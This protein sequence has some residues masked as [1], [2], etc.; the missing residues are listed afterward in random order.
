M[1]ARKPT[2]GA[3]ELLKALR[4]RLG[5]TTRDVERKSQQIAE[6]KRN[7]EY[8]LS[9]AW[10]T[11][12]ENG[13]FT[14]SIYKLYSLSAIYDQSF[15]ELLSFFGLRIGDLY[16]DRA[17]I[18][19][20]K[21]H[22]LNTASDM[23]VQKVFLPVQFKPEFRLERTNLLARVVEKWDEVPV[24][25]LQHLDLRKSMYGYIGLQDFT[26]FPLIRPGS[27]VQIDPSERKISSAKWKTEFDRPIYFIE[28]RDGYACSWCQ[29]D[30]GQLMV[31]PHPHSHQDVRRFEYPSEAEIVGRVTGLAMR[32]VG[33]AILGWRDTSHDK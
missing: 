26:L 9:H 1:D 3:G 22:L 4:V 20:P 14:P 11:D 24:G 15:T 17:S 27:L 32:I 16:R 23:E 12:I 19:V 31:I 18:G 7:Q 5:L 33:E 25:L 30:R 13:E 28:L 8:Y 6:E 21:T 10:L 29:V 2:P